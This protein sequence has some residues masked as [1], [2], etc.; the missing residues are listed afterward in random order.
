[1]VVDIIP[2]KNVLIVRGSVPGGT[3]SLLIVRDSLKG[4]KKDSGL[5]DEIKKSL[6]PLKASNRMARGG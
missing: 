3:N 2:E 5:K 6:N 4:K 1:M